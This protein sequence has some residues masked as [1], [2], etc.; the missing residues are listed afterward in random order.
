MNDQNKWI[1][2]SFPPGSP[3]LLSLINSAVL[4]TTIH[5][6]QNSKLQSDVGLCEHTNHF[7]GEVRPTNDTE[8][9]GKQNCNP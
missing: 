1:T 8:T 7:G 6:V 2:T 5:S 3:L 4:E 9:S